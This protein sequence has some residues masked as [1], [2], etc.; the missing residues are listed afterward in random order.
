MNKF[1]TLLVQ[2]FVKKNNTK[3]KKNETD[4]LINE[5]IDQQNLRT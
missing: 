1:V 3:R 2:L 4:K 5:L